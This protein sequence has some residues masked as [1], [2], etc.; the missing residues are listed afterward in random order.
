MAT[1]FVQGRLRDSLL[2]VR[3]DTECAHCRQEIHIDLDSAGVWR[4]EPP[5]ANPLVFEPRLDWKNF[6]KP[7][8]ID[9][10]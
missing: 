9:D 10:Y 2:T 3:I 6:T 7:N 8:I 5:E 1:P 4:V